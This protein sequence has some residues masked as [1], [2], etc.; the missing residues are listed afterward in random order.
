MIDRA[1]ILGQGKRLEVGKALGMPLGP[2]ATQSVPSDDRSDTAAPSEQANAG[3]GMAVPQRLDDVMRE[4]IERVLAA[5]HGKIEGPLGTAK[6]LDINPHTLRRCASSESTGSYSEHLPEWPKP[7]G[8][9]G[10]LLQGW[11]NRNSTA[12]DLVRACFVAGRSLRQCPAAG[13]P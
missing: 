5:T 12:G 1:V 3:P 7:K 4:H 13:D 9:S 8:A 2:T 10:P 6:V 11:S